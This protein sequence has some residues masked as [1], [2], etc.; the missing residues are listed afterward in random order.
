MKL[1]ARLPAWKRSQRTRELVEMVKREFEGFWIN[2]ADE[3][4]DVTIACPL[5]KLTEQVI[6][7]KFSQLKQ[8]IISIPLARITTSQ[9][10]IIICFISIYNYT[11]QSRFYSVVPQGDQIIV[12][13]GMNFEDLN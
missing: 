4:F 12:L 3:G 10:R 1:S 2:A 5:E 8:K 9:Q 7:T 6:E 13:F 11:G